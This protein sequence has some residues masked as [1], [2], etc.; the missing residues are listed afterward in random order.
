MVESKPVKQE[1]NRTLYKSPLQSM[2]WWYRDTL[3]RKVKETGKSQKRKD[4]KLVSGAN[5][6]NCDG[7]WVT[8]VEMRRQQWQNNCK[9]LSKLSTTNS[10]SLFTRIICLRLSFLFTSLNIF[11]F[12]NGPNPAYFCLFSFFSHGKYSTNAI[13]DKNVDGGLGTRTQGGR[14]VG[15]VESTVLWALEN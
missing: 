1:V 10:L 14:I 3:V 9:A 8:L 7:K 13:N 5:R 11:L 4:Y 12:L 15:A 6:T 2:V